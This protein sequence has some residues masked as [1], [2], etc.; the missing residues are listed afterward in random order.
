MME[1]DTLT[2]AERTLAIAL[3]AAILTAADRF[4]N[5][6]LK[7]PDPWEHTQPTV[8]RP[9][10]PEEIVQEARALV[11]WAEGAETGGTRDRP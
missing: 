2:P 8:T 9:R 11:A 1:S 10:L 4:A 7:G 3:I 6:A 5:A